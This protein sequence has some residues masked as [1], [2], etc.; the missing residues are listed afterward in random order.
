MSEP[1][2]QTVVSMQLDDFCLEVALILGRVLNVQ[3]SR[4]RDD[5]RGGPQPLQTRSEDSDG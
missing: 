3:G 4:E 5:P 1:E 2:S